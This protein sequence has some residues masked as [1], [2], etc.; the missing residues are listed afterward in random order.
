MFWVR[1]RQRSALALPFRVALSGARQRYQGMPFVVCL[2]DGEELRFGL[3]APAW[4][5]RLHSWRA[6]V[7]L[8]LRGI[9]GIG[10]A[11]ARVE[12]SIDGLDEAL[13][14]LSRFAAG[15]GGGLLD[16]LLRRPSGRPPTKR[17]E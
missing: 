4:R 8:T 17:L 16:G 6:A 3:G 12:A 13:L 5:V 2:P 1:K 10:A 11:H 7:D 14:G 9:P 15:Q